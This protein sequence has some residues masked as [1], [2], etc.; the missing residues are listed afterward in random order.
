MQSFLSRLIKLQF[1]HIDCIR[2][3]KNG[4]CSAYCTILL[5]QDVST[6]QIKNEIK[7]RLEVLLVLV[8]KSIGDTGE[9][10]LHFLQ[11]TIHIIFI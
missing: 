2:H 9:I 8:G 6:H 5:H 1:H 3:M 11:S 10:S 4:I 7:D